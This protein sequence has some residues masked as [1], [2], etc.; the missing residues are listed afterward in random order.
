MINGPLLSGI[1]A[2][3]LKAFGQEMIITRI[4]AIILDTLIIIMSYKIME[5]LE[6]KDYLKYIVVII[7]AIIMKKYFNKIFWSSNSV[8]NFYNNTFK[9]KCNK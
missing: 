2:I 1:S 8:S 3:F 5:K 7:L 4:L 9:I 6:I